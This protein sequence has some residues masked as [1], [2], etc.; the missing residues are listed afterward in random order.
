MEMK[1]LTQQQ[2]QPSRKSRGLSPTAT[3]LICTNLALLFIV[4]WALA[5]F[6]SIRGA[7]GYY[8]RGVT[9][10]VDSTEKSF[11]VAS[12]GDHVDVTFKLFNRGR[13]PIRVLGCSANCG[14]MVPRDSPFVLSPSEGRDFKVSIDIPELERVRSRFA[15]LELVLFT[16]H[17]VQSRIPLHIKG[18]IGGKPNPSQ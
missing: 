10:F 17:E 4:V 16:N 13:E 15:N 12:S 11:G 7:I 2:V 9:L 18:E 14:C 8:L 5:S 1:P 6:G 3:I